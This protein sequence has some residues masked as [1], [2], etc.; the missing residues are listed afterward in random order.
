MS[1]KR[2]RERPGRAGPAVPNPG[3]S[4]PDRD[5]LGRCRPG[6][7]R[8]RRRL[9]AGDRG[10][11]TAELAAAMPVFVLLLVFGLT[12][13]HA[14]GT[15]VRC[16]AA[17]R[18]A[19]LAEARGGG[20]ERAGRLVAP[21]GADVSVSSDGDLARATVSTRVHLFGR[22]LPVLTVSAEAVAAVEPGVP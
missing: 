21:P 1:G 19:A 16:L 2:A 15:K 4:D 14:T 12:A 20:G 6:R 18:D 8:S 22:R 9:P 11:A 10:S 17:A 13:V 5:G 3:V 7:P